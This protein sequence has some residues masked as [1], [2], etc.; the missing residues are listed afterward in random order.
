MY[1]CYSELFISKLPVIQFL[2]SSS[3]LK[4]NKNADENTQNIV[5]KDHFQSVQTY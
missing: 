2:D 1:L 4:Q 3:L 5:A